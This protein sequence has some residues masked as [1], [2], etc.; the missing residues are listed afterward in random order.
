VNFTL[1][2]ERAGGLRLQLDGDLTMPRGKIV[3]R[4]PLDSALQEVLMNGKPTLNFT[5]D[6]VVIDELPADVVMR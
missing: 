6:E 3:A 1:Q 5:A 2:R 4:P